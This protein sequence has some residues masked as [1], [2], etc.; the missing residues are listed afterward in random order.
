[1]FRERKN[2]MKNNNI[3]ADIKISDDVVASIVGLAA[4]EVEG[5][6]SLAGNVTNE[7]LARSGTK[8]RSK[9]VKLIIEDGSVTTELYMNIRYGYSIPVVTSQVQERVSNAIENMSGLKVATVNVHVV[10]IDVD[11]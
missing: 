3:N 4:T 11:R 2:K 8:N 1:M 5:V 6:T 10:G 7:R 9:G